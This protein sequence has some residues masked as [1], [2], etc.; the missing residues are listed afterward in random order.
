MNIDLYCYFNVF[1]GVFVFCEVVLCVVCCGVDVWVLIDYDQVV[2]LLE[3]CMVVLEVGMWF[4]VGVEILVIW[5]G[6]M[7]YIVGLCIDF[8]NLMLVVGFVKVCG[9]RCECVKCMVEELKVSGIDGVYEG[10]L[11]YVENLDMVG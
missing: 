9:G 11:G 7:L 4:V 10:V 3:V 5:W 6:S 2:G 8:G 1:D